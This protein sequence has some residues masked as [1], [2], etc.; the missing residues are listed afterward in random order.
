MY[1]VNMESKDFLHPFEYTTQSTPLINCSEL[2]NEVNVKKVMIKDESKNFTGTYKDRRS[3]EIVKFAVINKYEYLVQIT[4]GNAGYS[5]GNNLKGTSIKLTNIVDIHTND[6]IKKC[7][8]SLNSTVKEVDLS[9]KVFTSEDLKDLV[10]CQNRRKVLDC[11]NGFS[12]AY[13][14]IFYEVEYEN[15]DY[16]VVPFGSGESF[17]GIID[18]IEKSHSSTKVIGIGVEDRI[19]SCAK[20]LCAI[21]TPY[22][23]RVK[24]VESKGHRLIRLSDEEIASA[25]QTSEKYV[26][27]EL[28]S[29]VVFGVF[30]RI[31]FDKDS[32]IILVN[33]GKGLY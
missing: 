26:N 11:S 15:A 27:C 12:H 24:D 4:A 14:S 2:S 29:S 17:F 30:N 21:W 13:E 32:T 33:S 18:A 22:E 20:K 25:Y 28:S 1:N 7:L 10:D 31:K 3:R 8:S 9:E 5:L 19:S 6:L 16:I 23:E